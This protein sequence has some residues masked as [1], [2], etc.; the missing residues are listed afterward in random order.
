MTQVLLA[1]LMQLFSPITASR[2]LVFLYLFGATALLADASRANTKIDWPKFVMLMIVGVVHAP[3]W[4]GEFNYQLGLLVFFGYV[5]WTT[6][7]PR[8][9]PAAIV[10]ISIVLYFCHALGL[11]MF[12]VYEGLRAIRQRKVVLFACEM[13]PVAILLVWYKLSD[14]R[15]DVAALE[16]MPQLRGVFDWLAYQVYQAAK[17]GPY[18]NFVYGGLSD[19]YRHKMLYFAGVGV[20]LIFVAGLLAILVKWTRRFVD[21]RDFGAAQLASIAFLIIGIFN[22]GSLLGIANAGERMLAPGLMLAIYAM[23]PTDRLLRYLAGLAAVAAVV[24]AAFALDGPRYPI[25]SPVMANTVVS[26]PHER[27][28]IL[29]WHKPFAFAAQA[30]EA[31]RSARTG[32]EA[33][34]GLAFETSVMLAKPKAQK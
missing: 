13:L 20:N 24:F 14:P 8:Q 25:A 1:V 17:M 16:T 5:H 12:L 6:K 18:H 11:G 33:R 15:T 28:H 27:L 7:E 21:E 10:A 22:L 23:P 2:I 31:Q 19:F 32:T 34:N 4:T 3:F 26:D 29:F 9:H 30:L